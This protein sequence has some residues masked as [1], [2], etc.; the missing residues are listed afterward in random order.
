M[1]TKLRRKRWRPDPTMD[2]KECVA[3]A[4]L[5]AEMAAR[6]A[7]AAIEWSRRT[8][9]GDDDAA[10]A[11]RAAMRA[12]IAFEHASAAGSDEVARIDTAM[13]WA[14]TETALEADQRVVEAI[15]RDLA[16]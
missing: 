16:D 7:T 2:R 1:K 12:R 11:V 6:A 13:A 10:E 4:E 8:G 5:A 9:V 14:A 15:A 3:E